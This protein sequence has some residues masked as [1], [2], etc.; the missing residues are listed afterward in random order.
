MWNSYDVLFPILVAIDE[1]SHLTMASR[2]GRP[3]LAALYISRCK[4]C[5]CSVPP[6]SSSLQI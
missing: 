6:N 1:H 4:V 3:T 2:R 5:I